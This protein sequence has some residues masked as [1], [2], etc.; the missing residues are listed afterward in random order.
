MEKKI[1]PSPPLL[2][3]RK[4]FRS[5]IDGGVEVER[6]GGNSEGESVGVTK[7]KTEAFTN[8]MF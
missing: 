6:R 3:L 8:Q 7:G 2:K 4:A 1:L 5:L